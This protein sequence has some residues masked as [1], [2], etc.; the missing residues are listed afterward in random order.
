MIFQI[1]HYR[2]P[3][4]N[5]QFLKDAPNVHW[6]KVT[7]DGVAP[8]NY[9]ALSIYPEYFKVNGQW[10][11][12]TKSR[13]D[14]VCV[15]NDEIGKESVKIVEFR[16]LKIGDKVVIGREE[17]GSCGIYVYDK[18][19]ITK[20]TEE[21]TFAF[22]QGRSRETA[23][24]ID[25]DQLYEILRHEKENNGHVTWVL[26]SALAFDE[27]A[28]R[29][30]EKIIEEDIVDCIICGNALAT[31]DLEKAIFGST[32]GQQV[33][34]REYAQT[35]NYMRTVNM[36]REAGS[37]E[38]FI[39]KYR[40][41]SGFVYLC[42]RKKIPLIIGGTIRDRFTL[43]DTYDNVYEAQDAMRAH[44]SKST[45]IIMVASVLFSIATGNMTPSYNEFDGK[46]RP[47]YIY[48]VDIQEFAVN[49]LADRGSLSAK[50][51][52]TNAQDFMKNIAR[53]MD[54]K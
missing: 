24:S 6:E 41:N 49:K 50:S 26:G 52:V 29:A 36:V 5:Q 35:K 53:A 13:M 54:R 10:I 4:F 40:I 19:F 45:A 37:M 17:D 34:S 8:K 14:T 39:Q 7:E 27:D 48:T 11:L 51:I 43:P 44:T 21:E 32:W 15:I 47:V 22:R 33:F 9:H 2:E 20:E 28:R 3:D 23:F 1:P 30:L 18:G 42:H 12:A 38:A 16:N 31:F 25:Y 46:I